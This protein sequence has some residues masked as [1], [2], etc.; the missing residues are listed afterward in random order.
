MLDVVQV[1]AMMDRSG[2]MVLQG[3]V[4]VVIVAVVLLN[5]HDGA[6]EALVL[7]EQERVAARGGHV[8]DAAV[9]FELEEAEVVAALDY[10]EAIVEVH[11]ANGTGSFVYS[12]R[13][14]GTREKKDA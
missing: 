13:I 6:G 12:C 2:L 8:A 3:K 7:F 5:C 10:G 11:Q 1:R 14:Y 9:R 4:G